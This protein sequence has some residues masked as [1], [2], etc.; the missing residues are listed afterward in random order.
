[1]GKSK[2]LAPTLY[3]G[4]VVENVE[5][6]FTAEKEGIIEI[7]EGTYSSGAASVYCWVFTETNS[8]GETVEKESYIPHDIEDKISIIDGYWYIPKQP[9]W[10]HASRVLNFSYT[11]IC[12]SILL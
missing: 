8:N 12:S 10:Q 3:A 11:L 4:G 2:A 7:L 1:M 9:F 6:T 5:F